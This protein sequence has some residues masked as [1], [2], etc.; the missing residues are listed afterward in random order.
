MAQLKL[1]FLHSLQKVFL[2]REPEAQDAGNILMLSNDVFDFQLAFNGSGFSSN[3]YHAQVTCDFEYPKAVNVYFVENV[4]CERTTYQDPDIYYE[5]VNPGLFPDVL[6]PIENVSR[7]FVSDCWYAAYVAVDLRKAKVPAGLYTLRIRLSCDEE[8]L[9]K[10]YLVPIEVLG[11]KLPKQKLRYTN[12]FHCDCIC[13][14]Y[15]CEMFSERHWKLIERFMRLAVDH[16]QNQILVPAFTPPLDTPIGKERKTAQLVGVSV[17]NG[18]YRFSFDAFIRYI[19]LAKRCGFTYFEHSHLFSQWGATMAPKIVATVRGK[20]KTIFGWNTDA[21]GKSYSKFIHQY[22]DALMPV[23]DALH[24]RKKTYFHVSD[25]PHIEDFDAYSKA[26]AVLLDALA[27]YRVSKY[28]I[29]D[30][31]SELEFLEKKQ[32]YAPIVCIHEVEPFFGKTAHLGF[33][34]TGML[35][36]GGYSNRLLSMTNSRTRMMGIQLYYFRAVC[37]LH[38]GY[39]FYYNASSQRYCNPFLTTDAYREF[40]GGTSYCVYPAEE[41]PIPSI[42]Q[43]AFAQGLNDYRALCLLES[44]KGREFVCA[45]IRDI[46]GTDFSLKTCPDPDDYLTLHT[47][48]QTIYQIL[49]NQTKEK[50][51]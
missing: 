30:A 26:R 24:I 49:S 11:E 50:K 37:F 32:I 21:A 8:S 41:G 18:N 17:E 25:E 45:L 1:K 38:W 31:L 14:A 39:N 16:G 5:R 51:Q 33:Y 2:D 34:Y 3:L 7:C 48:R 9:E 15:G 13:D 43:K 46:F 44:Q 47:F 23:L 6:R 40:S 10:E 4:P 20:T 12:W 42:R 36:K 27:P 22:I 19:Q 29:V 28:Q 35:P